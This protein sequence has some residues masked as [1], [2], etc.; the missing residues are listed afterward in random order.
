MPEDPPQHRPTLRV[1]AR[2]V[3]L[4]LAATSMAMRNHPGISAATRLR[5]QEVARKLG[6]H[7]DPKLATLMQHLRTNSN[8]EYR[9]TLAYLSTHSH[10][11]DWKAYSQHDYYV[12]AANRAL[13]LGYRVEIF[14]LGSPGMTPSRI[15]QMLDAR[16]V[17]GLL[18]GGFDYP[19]ARLE[20]DWERFAAVTFA[21][22]ITWP[23]LHRVT[24]DY[25]RE[26]LTVLRRLEDEGYRRIGLNVKIEDDMKVIGLWR[27]AYLLYQA[28]LPI[29]RRLRINI[30][31]DLIRWVQGQRPDAIISAGCDFPQDWETRCKQPI[32][33]VRYV[34]MNIHHADCRSQGIDQ[35]SATVGRIACEHLIAMLQRNEIGLPEQPQITSVEGRW[36][37]EYDAWFAS[38]KIQAHFVKGES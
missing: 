19:E 13:D 35:D 33:S 6:Y 8:S 26:M 36:I 32:P 20:L 18:I 2:E 23:R 31:D 24:T 5:V 21:Y 25:Y 37:D 9:E 34:N 10:Y 28:S 14:H 29:K 30:K 11:E 7:S 17:R 4:S 3:G 22:S 1:I 38:R 12:G 16:G 15:S 27:A